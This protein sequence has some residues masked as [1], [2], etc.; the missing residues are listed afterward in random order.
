LREV[1]TM[2]IRQWLVL[3]AG[4]IVL[5]AV[6]ATVVFSVGSGDGSDGEAATVSEDD[7]GGGAAAGICIEGT[8][9]CVDTV[10]P[11]DV[12]DGGDTSDG[13]DAAPG[14]PGNPDAPVTNE[15]DDGDFVDP[16]GCGLGSSS[17]EC[18]A[19]ATQLALE[20]LSARLGVEVEAIAVV[21]VESAVWD[22]CMGIAPVEGE[23]CTEIGIPGYLIILSHGGETYEY[24]TD[25]G[26]RAI[27][28]Q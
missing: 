16:S 25:S 26:S 15:P 19:A 21:S 9:D 18:E 27:P 7:S 17:E 1:K 6:V 4:A 20:D 11:G 8:V 5:A 13:G 14:D 10:E 23:V 3:G 2:S 22:G 24:H 28:A 12:S